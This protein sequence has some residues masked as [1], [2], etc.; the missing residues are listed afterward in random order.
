MRFDWWNWC[1]VEMDDGGD[2]YLSSPDCHDNLYVL[3]YRKKSN[4]KKPRGK[5]CHYKIYQFRL[6]DGELFNLLYSGSVSVHTDL[7]HPVE[8]PDT[9]CERVAK[10][11]AEQHIMKL[12]KDRIPNVDITDVDGMN[13]PW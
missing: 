1:Q 7:L 2:G 3:I 9:A 10:G 12:R 4:A 8:S 11:I 5:V 6:A 13:I